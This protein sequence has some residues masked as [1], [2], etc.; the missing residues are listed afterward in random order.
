LVAPVALVGFD[1]M[2]RE[3][4]TGVEGDDRDLSLIH[5]GEDTTTSMGTGVRPT[6]PRLDRVEATLPRPGEEPV[7]VTA[8]DAVLRCRGGDGQLAGDD[9]EDGHLMLRHAADCHACP[10]S[11][12]TDQLSPMS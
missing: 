4:F 12:V 6:R 3:D 8:T 10:D 7:Q 2:A 9:L 5:D 11:P 1:E